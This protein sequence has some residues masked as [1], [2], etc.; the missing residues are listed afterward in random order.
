MPNSNL[1]CALKSLNCIAT[2][3]SIM[4]ED[5]KKISLLEVEYDKVLS[6]S[7]T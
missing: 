2:C 7:A 1:G 3:V 6:Q 5:V 4:D